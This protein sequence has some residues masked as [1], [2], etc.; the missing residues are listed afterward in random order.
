[1]D[2]LDLI[3][4]IRG[5]GYSVIADGSYLDISPTSDLSPD[6]NIPA[7]LMRQLE[8]NKPEILCA[9][10]RE[11]ELLRLVFL[12][13]NHQGFSQQEYQETIVSALLDQPNSLIRFAAHAHAL[14][15]L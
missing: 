7:E 9:L 11:A 2:A 13:S 10:H 6:D 5:R 12:V 3:F 4:K 1:M 15:L 8:Q 14:G